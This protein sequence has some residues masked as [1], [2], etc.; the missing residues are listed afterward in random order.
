MHKHAYVS[1]LLLISQ[2]IF[3]GFTQGTLVHTP[4]GYKNIETLRPGDDI[5]SVTKNGK[6]HLDRVKYI[7]NHMHDVSMEII[8]DDEMIV[9]SP[10]Q[11]FY[12]ASKQ[13]WCTAKNLAQGDVVRLGNN[14]RAPVQSISYVHQTTQ[15]CDITLEKIHAFCITSQKIVVHNSR[16]QA[17]R[18][19]SSSSG[20]SSS[21]SSDSSSITIE[22]GSSRE[23]R[24]EESRTVA[25]EDIRREEPRSVSY[26]STTTAVR[27]DDDYEERRERYYE[28]SRAEAEKKRIEDEE[29]NNRD[30][31][32]RRRAR[33]Y[34][35]PKEQAAREVAIAREKLAAAELAYE[36]S[37][38][39][40][41][42]VVDAQ[43]SLLVAVT[44]KAELIEGF[45]QTYWQA[46]EKLK[47]ANLVK[48]LTSEELSHKHET[49]KVVQFDSENPGR[50]LTFTRRDVKPEE[51]LKP[52]DYDDKI[53]ERLQR[54]RFQ[55]VAQQTDKI[56]V[57]IPTREFYE[58]NKDL[59]SVPREYN[60]HPVFIPEKFKSSEASPGSVML[61]EATSNGSNLQ[62][63]VTP[64]RGSGSMPPLDPKDPKNSQGT[65]AK[66]VI[67]GALTATAYMT[68]AAM[69]GVAECA[70]TAGAIAV[71]APLAPVV[72]G[73]VLIG[74]YVSVSIPGFRDPVVVQ[75]D[76]DT[77]HM[78]Q[79][80]YD[81]YIQAKAQYNQLRKDAIEARQAVEAN[82]IL[83]QNGKYKESESGNNPII[84][85]PL[86]DP[87]LHYCYGNGQRL[88]DIST[89]VSGST[90]RL[91]VQDDKV[92]KFTKDLYDNYT[93]AV[94]EDLATLSRQDKTALRD[95]FN[96]EVKQKLKK[97]EQQQR[98]KDKSGKGKGGGGGPDDKDPNQNNKNAKRGLLGYIGDKAKK[99][100]DEM[101][102]AKAA[103]A[104]KVV[105]DAPKLNSRG[106]PMKYT[107]VGYH[108]KNSSGGH[109]GGKSPGPR[110][111]QKSLN[112]SILFK[113]KGNQ[114]YER[115]IGVEEDY[116][117]IFDEQRPGEY[118]G[119]I[120][121]WDDLRGEVQDALYEAGIVKNRK[122]GKR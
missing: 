17:I 75:R 87:S 40:K 110:D 89:S 118:H 83:F 88:L 36:Q 9:V 93:A 47:Y 59:F 60:G 41:K 46:P 74:C 66:N 27:V 96:Y 121:F 90:D 48:K 2:S 24:Q 114:G 119:H 79:A 52:L 35:S 11:R 39:R 1:L 86:V 62:A 70:G 67:V 104:A 81:A 61:K 30:W 80:E 8:I 6:L 33:S 13:K 120:D 116:Y 51:D 42:A 19:S 38:Q 28:D 58:L 21:S 69:V 115:R 44:T 15:F 23:S 26:A 82:E 50:G 29:W 18:S 111:G 103:K 112:D 113:E 49:P 91:A 34:V 109:Q 16:T 56:T 122:T 54:Y 92:I 101:E 107:G 108:H 68:G 105:K 71:T 14:S 37:L 95:Y 5:Y 32:E 57:F 102:A 85:G 25:V 65:D 99:K 100:L 64:A 22:R 10:E 63:H 106:K 73:T 55:K 12:L 43:R 84:D 77:K 3:A 97:Q 76:V 4:H 72:V 117:V 98:E 94:V 20:S 7:S 78:T 45:V 31:E 53:L